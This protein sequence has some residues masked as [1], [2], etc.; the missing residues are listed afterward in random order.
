MN[1][2]LSE[3][4][5][6]LRERGI[7]SYRP[8]PGRLVVSRQR[9]PVWP[10]RGNSF[11]LCRPGAG[12]HV[13]TWAPFYYRVPAASSVVDVA[14]AFMSV[15]ESAQARVPAELVAR[16]ALTEVDHGEF[17]RTWDAAQPVD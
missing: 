13:C 4:E 9:G 8:Q 12:W 10:D 11:W 17:E 7:S 16:F 3:I 15:G 1:D 6:R 5:Q 14:E 2:E